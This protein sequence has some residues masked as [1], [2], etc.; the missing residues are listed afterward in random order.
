[1]KNND[2]GAE[3]VKHESCTA[4]IC[5]FKNRDVFRLEVRS[6]NAEGDISRAI[7]GTYGCSLLFEYLLPKGRVRGE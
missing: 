1:M 2:E 4:K 5:R 3:Q 7:F 6:Y